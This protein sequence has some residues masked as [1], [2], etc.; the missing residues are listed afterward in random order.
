MTNKANAMVYLDINNLFFLYKKLNY[1]KLYEWL[2]EQY[3]CLRVT[4]Y[5]S[6]DHKNDAQLKFHVYLSNNGYKVVDPD[7]SITT[8]CDNIIVTDICHNSNDFDHKVIVLV[9]CDGDYSYTLNELSKKGYMV[10][11]IGIKEKT[12]SSLVNVC[13]KITYIEDINDVII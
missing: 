9:S 10:H 8:N 11:V 12:S 7:I 6:I 13:D 1:L 2:T 3:N 4:A 5:N